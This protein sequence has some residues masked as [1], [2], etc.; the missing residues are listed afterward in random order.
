MFDRLM[1]RISG[2]DAK[3]V[4]GNEV[5]RRSVYESEL[6]EADLHFARTEPGGVEILAFERDFSPTDAEDNGY[7]LLT[8]G[9]SDRA[10]TMPPQALS[11]GG[12]ARA[13]LIWYVREP[14]DE[15]IAN[16]RWLAEFPFIDAI[17]LGFGHRVPMPTPPLDTCNFRTFLFLTPII[18]PDKRIAE[19]LSIDNERVE[20]LTV[21]LISDPEY[22]LIKAEGL[23]PFLDLLDENDYPPIF[24]PTRKSYV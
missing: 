12:K 2:K 7:V 5:V 15:I 18:G 3:T 8:S 16:L 9:M 22:A 17:W 10:M 24:D 4:D 14:T 23:D 1:A 19:T 11:A 20:I 13:E 21:N 6:G